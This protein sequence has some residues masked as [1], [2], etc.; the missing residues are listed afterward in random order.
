MRARPVLVLIVL[1]AAFAGAAVATGASRPPIPAGGHQLAPGQLPAVCPEGAVANSYGPT[2]G[3]YYDTEVDQWVGA[4]WCYPR[5]GNLYMS[6]SQVTNAGSAVTFTAIPTD[7]SNS[8]SFAPDTRS[9]AWDAAGAKIVAG[10]GNVDLTCTII[11]AAKAGETWQWVM[12]HVSMPRTFLVDSPG[13]NCAGQHLCAGV[14]TNA[15][16]YAGVRPK[17]S[18]PAIIHGRVTDDDKEPMQGITVAATGASSK[19]AVTD[20]AGRY[21]LKLKRA[22]SYKVRASNGA[23]AFAPSPATV[24]AREGSPTTQNFELKGCAAKKARAAK[25]H[26]YHFTSGATGSMTYDDCS[27]EVTLHWSRTTTC[28]PAA[29][30]SGTWSPD[31]NKGFRAHRDGSRILFATNPSIYTHRGSVTGGPTPMLKL[32]LGVIHPGTHQATLSVAAYAAGIPTCIGSGGTA[33]YFD[34]TLAEDE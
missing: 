16:A 6:P 7:G 10:C 22:G 20:A 23:G 12:V 3:F 17:R 34:E 29:T 26:S 4:P 33:G 18:T 9:I 30:F 24:R 11:P 8:A 5:W 25:V 1:V 2:E 21:E 14:T 32:V 31:L 19:S 28:S 27:G 15:W 13:S